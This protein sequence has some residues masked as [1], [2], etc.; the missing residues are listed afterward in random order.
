MFIR[1]KIVE[2]GTLRTTL[3][4]TL[5]SVFFS[6]SL[7]LIIANLLKDHIYLSGIVASMLIPALIAPWFSWY[8]VKSFMKLHRLELEMRELATFD[9]LTK[10]Y[11]RKMFFENAKNIFEL[12]KRDKKPFSVLYIDLDN[13]KPINDTFGHH[14]GDEVLK[15]F[16]KILLENKRKSDIVGRTG[17]EEFAI[18]LPQTNQFDAYEYAEKIRIKV[19]EIN[20][21]YEDVKLNFTISIGVASYNRN[22]TL[23]EIFTYADE[24]LY[25]AKKEAKNKVVLYKD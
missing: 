9:S 8:F 21:E 17:S 7:Y 10:V 1:E 18:V 16:G 15:V 20:L 13:F 4:V 19:S 3:I 25:K 23:K 14:I 24:S 5:L 6:L 22:K 11:T 12:N 2:F